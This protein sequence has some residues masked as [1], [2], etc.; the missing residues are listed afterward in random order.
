MST[1]DSITSLATVGVAGFGLFLGYSIWKDIEKAVDVGGEYEEEGKEFVDDGVKA[2]DTAVKVLG[3]V[4][5]VAGG[6][7]ET[8][9][10]NDESTL[11]EGEIC[12]D[13]AQC[14]STGDPGGK[15]VGLDLMGLQSYG[16]CRGKCKRK[17]RNFLGYDCGNPGPE[18]YGGLNEPCGS[19]CSKTGFRSTERAKWS[20]NP[21][22]I[23]CCDGKCKILLKDGERVPEVGF[24][25]MKDLECTTEYQV[26]REEE[27]QNQNKT[28]EQPTPQRSTRSRGRTEPE[29]TDEEN[30]RGYLGVKTFY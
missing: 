8:V 6:L 17:R 11:G 14:S 25:G 22:N 21:L 16:C 26:V 1:I 4:G 18:I 10:V 27:N 30:F 23:G 24:N 5:D 9:I 12:V 7:L 13:N 15:S 29:T 28:S 19:G 3:D 2:A 20:D